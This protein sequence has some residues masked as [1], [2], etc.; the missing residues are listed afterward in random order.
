MFR[1]DDKDGNV[2]NTTVANYLIISGLL[3]SNDINEPISY[4]LVNVSY[5][6]DKELSDNSDN[7]EFDSYSEELKKGKYR[8]MTKIYNSF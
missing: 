2:K 5:D 7:I 3:N 1:N 6:I 8:D 4:E